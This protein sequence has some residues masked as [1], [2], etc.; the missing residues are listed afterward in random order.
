M[1]AQKAILLEVNKMGTKVALMKV[2]PAKRVQG[3]W[4]EW[5][6]LALG[7][8]A[9]CLEKNGVECQIIDAHFEGLSPAQTITRAKESGAT[10][11]GITVKTHEVNLVHEI[12]KRLKA[13]IPTA[14]VVVGGSHITALPDRTM[15]EFPAFDY[16]VVGEGE[17]TL[18]ELVHAL[19]NDGDLREI[20][21]LIYRGVGDQLVIN[22]PR[23]VLQDLDSL[24]FPAWHLYPRAQ[25]YPMYTAR[26]C[27]FRCK[28][29]MRVLGSRVRCRSP[30]NVVEEFEEILDKHHPKRITFQDETFA[31]NEKWAHQLAE[32]MIQ[33]GLHKRVEWDITTRAD[34]ADES[35][36]RKL[37]DA[38]CTLV[39]LGIESGNDYVLKR[40]GKDITTAQAVRAV[41]SAKRAGLRTS[42]YFIIGHPH[43]TREEVLDTINFASKLNTDLVAFGL[44]VPY[45]GTQIYEMAMRGEGGYKMLSS[46]WSDFDKYL[47]NALELESLDRRT[48]ELLQMRAYVTFYLRNLR[49][50]EAFRFALEKRWA[51]LA[52]LRKVLLA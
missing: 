34:L 19:D 28:F 27:P 31:V 3:L 47:G 21:G 25:V 49:L 51:I 39:G 6:T 22:K 42:A 41:E 48:M 15:G 16:A 1:S 46:D 13:I 14:R 32:L 20:D 29:C 43:E 4:Y 8:L 11:F 50:F 30:Q 40:V 35:L 26:G 23:Q 52:A 38:G 37:R 7:Y 9:A 10:L 36:Y 24:P 45:P 2:A 17:R 12:A 44:M 5:P 18:V 33:R